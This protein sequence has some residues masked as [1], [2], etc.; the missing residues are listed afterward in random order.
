MALMASL[1]GLR[2]LAGSH[3]RSSS[4]A[5][6]LLFPHQPQA[7]ARAATIITREPLPPVVQGPCEGGQ[8]PPSKSCSSW[9]TPPP[10]VDEAGAMMP[11]RH[12]SASCSC[13]PRAEG[14]R[15]RTPRTRFFVGSF[16]SSSGTQQGAGLLCALI[17]FALNVHSPVLLIHPTLVAFG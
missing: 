17:C 7:H 12:R 11:P 14:L 6:S 15:R 13:T 9:P 10:L 8:A 5:R 16:I 1:R 4:P 3:A 2:S